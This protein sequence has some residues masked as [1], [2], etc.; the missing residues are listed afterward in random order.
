MNSLE[1]L[2]GVLDQPRGIPQLGIDRGLCLIGPLCTLAGIIFNR[3]TVAASTYTTLITDHTIGV[4]YTATGA[5]TITISSAH[6]AVVGKH[7]RIIDE[8]GNASVHNI[9]VATEGSET[10]SGA[11]T[12]TISTDYGRLRIYSDGSN[13]FLS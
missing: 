4:T 2:R 7:I 5:V 13:C 11:A 1:R 12:Q 10:I 9:T 3:I 8:G 6:I